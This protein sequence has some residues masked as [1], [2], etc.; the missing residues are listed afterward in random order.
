MHHPLG[1]FGAVRI[2]P[3]GPG[4]VRRDMKKVLVVDDEQSILIYLT[5][6]LEDGGYAA[7]SAIDGEEGLRVARKEIPDLVCLDVMMPKRSGVSLY[8]SIKRDPELR[9]IPVLFISAYNR[10]R[11]LRNPL[12]FRK[13][14]PDTAI[15]EP[16]LC[17]EKPIK[18][19]DFLAAVARLT[20]EASP[21]EKD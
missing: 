7:C 13:M 21:A 3:G 2:V 14:I 18:V 1:A 10:I 8:E 9:G 20:G 4:G 11:D 16:E 12:A 17:M 6:V 5:T 15:P 19:P